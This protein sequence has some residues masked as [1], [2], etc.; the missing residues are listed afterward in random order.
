MIRF[1][2]TGIFPEPLWLTARD[3][4]RGRI[5]CRQQ[6]CPTPIRINRKIEPFQNSP[7]MRDL[8]VGNAFFPLSPFHPLCRPWAN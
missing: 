5:P 1:S 3:N 4:H 6:F 7:I 8:D 2:E